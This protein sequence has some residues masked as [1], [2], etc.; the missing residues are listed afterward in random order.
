MS[1]GLALN[2]T[3]LA[4]FSIVVSLIFIDFHRFSVEKA[5]GPTAP[6]VRAMDYHGLAWILIE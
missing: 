5:W 1:I 6:G 2:Y 4:L 3:E